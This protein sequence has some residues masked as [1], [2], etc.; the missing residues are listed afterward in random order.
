MRYKIRD[1]FITGFFLVFIFLFG[2]WAWLKDDQAMSELEGRALAAEPVKDPDEIASGEYFKKYDD[3]YSDQ[4]PVRDKWIEGSAI[5]DKYILQKEYIKDVYVNDNGYLISPV[6]PPEKS[7][8][9]DNVNSKINDFAK[10]L[11]NEG[12]STYFALVPNKSTMMENKL[13]Y[14]IESY[15]N[16][17][18]DNLL[19][20]FSN[21]VKAL[22]FREEINAHLNE[23]NM[24]FYTDHHWKPK[25]AFYAYEKLIQTIGEEY[26]AVGGSL[27]KSD[28]KWEEHPTPFYGSEAR[29]TTAVHVKKPDTVT[30]VKPIKNQ[31]PLTVCY[32]GSCDKSFYNMNSL[33]STDFYMNRYTTYLSG[34]V[35]EGI[36]KNPNVDNEL[37]VLILKDSYANAMIQFIAQN[38]EETRFLDLRKHENMDVKEYANAHDIDI[39]L[40]VHNINSIVT[41]PK[42]LNL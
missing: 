12:V 24:Y 26:P 5:I 22:D 9:V 7:V 8:A 23:K 40:F 29:K 16:D 36:V 20:G 3:Y 14:Y 19:G 37:K 11:H 13:P 25:A 18:S 38:F 21:D 42:F 41:T 39:V 33:N 4:F 10:N 17:L 15:A 1:L 6:N 35:P 27:K 2:A 32:S 28:F 34:D 31:K 30:V